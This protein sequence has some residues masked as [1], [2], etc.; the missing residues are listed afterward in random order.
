MQSKDEQT[1]GHMPRE[2]SRLSWYFLK[3]GGQII[4]EVTGRRS[5]TPGKGLEVPCLHT[6][7]DKPALIKILIKVLV[8]KK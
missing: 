6:F 5:S 4:C 8:V 3:H 1:V 7:K 2:H